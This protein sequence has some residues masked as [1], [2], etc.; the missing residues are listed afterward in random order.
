MGAYGNV[1]IRAT[2]LIRTG[3][4]GAASEAW[5]VAVREAFPG[6]L[7]SQKKGCPRGAYLGL[8]E[9]GLVAGVPAGSYTGSR[10]NKVY[11]LSALRLLETDATLAAESQASLWRRVM[12]G[13]EK[14][15]NH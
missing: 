1:A 11:A 6:K 14:R 5:Q 13:Q 7:P 4:C 3:R 15:P 10:V 2:A 8:C 12:K 9:E